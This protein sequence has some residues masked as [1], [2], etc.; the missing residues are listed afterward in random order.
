MIFLAHIGIRMRYFGMILSTV[1]LSGGLTASAV[2]ESLS[3]H[4]S[5]WYPINEPGLAR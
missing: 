2:L 3:Q 5:L 1:R 4:P